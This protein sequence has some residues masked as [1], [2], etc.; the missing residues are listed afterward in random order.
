MRK[1]CKTISILCAAILINCILFG[2]IKIY[3]EKNENESKIINFSMNVISNNQIKD[4]MKTSAVLKTVKDASLTSG[5]I[6]NGIYLDGNG[7]YL[8][9]SGDGIIKN[10]IRLSCSMWV[11]P[12][13]NS[14]YNGIMPLIHTDN[15]DLFINCSDGT[16]Q[17]NA[18]S[19]MVLKS[20]CSL[21]NDKDDKWYNIVLTCDSGNIELYINGKS[22]KKINF[23]AFKGINCKSALVGYD[24][25]DYFCGNTD[26]LCV[27]N[28]AL[29]KDEVYEI[30]NSVSKSI[31]DW[32]YTSYPV[33]SSYPNGIS[34]VRPELFKESKISKPIETGFESRN[35]INAVKDD[36]KNKISDI[37]DKLN[38]CKV[39]SNEIINKFKKEL[40][41]K[42][43]EYEK[44]KLELN[45]NKNIYENNKNNYKK[46]VELKNACFKELNRVVD[47]A[48]SKSKELKSLK[49]RYDYEK[50][51]NER[52][53]KK[54][55]Y[56]I[57]EKD[58]D[59]WNTKKCSIFVGFKKIY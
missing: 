24:G 55:K 23:T 39:D 10:K 49:N 5:I 43:I 4:D 56:V 36:N 40:K 33:V 17:L 57:D 38:K 48:N 41:I 1:T 9:Y 2:N 16:L 13:F 28:K 14:Q 19:N 52:Y 31:T 46:I 20:D 32:D 12:K 3:A 51:Y 44:C 27:Y 58:V 21:K 37:N 47:I 18:Y 50:D 29:N 22:D 34:A 6:E 54:L 8:Q 42:E 11:K 26:E 30:Y 35:E 53:I 15:M 7:S 59:Y 25:T 45:D